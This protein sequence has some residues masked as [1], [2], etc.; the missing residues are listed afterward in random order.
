MKAILDFFKNAEPNH[1][2]AVLE[3][4][5]DHNQ[6]NNKIMSQLSEL[7]ASLNALTT[8]L[9]SIDTAV[10]ALVA[11]AANSNV[12]LDAPTQAALDALT[13]EVGTVATDAN[14]A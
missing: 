8:K 4:L 9:E 5:F 1:A 12:T 10:K 2:L 14:A 13:A 7:A 11:A 3:L 6:Q